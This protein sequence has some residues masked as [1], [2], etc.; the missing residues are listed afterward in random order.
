M[1]PMYESHESLH[2][3]RTVAEFL[4]KKWGCSVFK[5][6]IKYKIDFAFVK[7]N[8]VVAWAEIK[9]RSRKYDEMFISL[10]KWLAG[11]E[12]SLSTGIPFVVVFAFD[13]G[14]YWRSVQGDDPRIVIGGREDRGDWQDIEPMAVFPIHGFKTWGEK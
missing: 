1:R 14:I 11:K 7:D 2:A 6:P 4:S 8:R 10:D 13:D 9:E 3:E 12:I 5:L